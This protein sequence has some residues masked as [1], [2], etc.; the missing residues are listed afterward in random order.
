MAASGSRSGAPS[1]HS[2]APVP[3]A[4]PIISHHAPWKSATVGGPDP[5]SATSTATPSAEPIC[6]PMVTTAMPV[7]NRAGG[8][9]AAPAPVRVGSSSPTPMP[10]TSMP[11]R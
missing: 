6:R 10:L 2:V 1:I 3:A 11:G 8:S 4:A 9:E 7:E 5:S